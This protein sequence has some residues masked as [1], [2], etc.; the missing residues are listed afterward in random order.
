MAKG[1]YAGLDKLK[2][3]TKG[4]GY[5]GSKA[6][7]GAFISPF[8]GGRSVRAESRIHGGGERITEDT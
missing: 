5:H 1:R 7:K 8:P 6:K 4:R 2:A 3:K